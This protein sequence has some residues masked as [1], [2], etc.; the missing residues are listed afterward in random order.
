MTQIKGE[1][2]DLETIVYNAIRDALEEMWPPNEAVLNAIHSGTAEAVQRSINP[3]E[4]PR[5][6]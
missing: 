6:F 2:F 5:A 1:P 4:P 3:F